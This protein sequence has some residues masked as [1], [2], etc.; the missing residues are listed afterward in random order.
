MVT[1]AIGGYRKGNCKFFLS[2]IVPELLLEDFSC[3]SSALYL[4]KAARG[5]RFQ[6]FSHGSRVQLQT[7]TLNLRC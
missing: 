5:S 4:T 7:Q 3:S 6:V 2:F 1:A